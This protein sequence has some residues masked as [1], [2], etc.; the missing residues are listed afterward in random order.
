MTRL[1]DILSD[2]WA[3]NL[4]QLDFGDASAFKPVKR[5]DSDLNA[6]AKEFAPGRQWMQ[7]QPR[8]TPITPQ[9]PPGQRSHPQ[10]LT[11]LQ[12]TFDY[13]PQTPYSAPAY[14]NNAPYNAAQVSPLVTIT[15]ATQQ[16]S[17]GLQWHSQYPPT[18]DIATWTASSYH[19]GGRLSVDYNN[20]LL[21]PTSPN[22]SQRSRS[23][24]VSVTSAATYTCDHPDC[25]KIFKAKTE[26]THHLRNHGPRN[27]ACPYCSKKFIFKKDMARHARTHTPD[28]RSFFCDVEAC[29]WAER[30][31]Q[32]KDHWRRHMLTH[33]PRSTG[34]L[35]P[36]TSPSATMSRSGSYQ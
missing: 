30:G 31:F 18:Q 29:Q 23:R 4:D 9:T 24:S 15:D 27:H 21:T 10:Q 20:N 35:T 1:Q 12:T 19:A 34:M 11:R 17:Q 3:L 7:Q 25:N 28:N 13:S 14:H 22:T 6:R 36:V 32:R 33:K 16:Y 2:P 26:F 5:V 8:Y